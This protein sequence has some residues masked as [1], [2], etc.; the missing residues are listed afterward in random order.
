MSLGEIPNGSLFNLY[1]FVLDN[2][3]VR[4]ILNVFTWLAMQRS[5]GPVEMITRC[6]IRA[7]KIRIS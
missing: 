1:F 5:I 3:Y 6:Y 4:S 2:K 7:A